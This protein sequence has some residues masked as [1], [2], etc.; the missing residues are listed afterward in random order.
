M[1]FERVNGYI[2]GLFS[3]NEL[4]RKAAYIQRTTLKTFTPVV[5]DDVARLLRLLVR[6]LRPRRILE[7]G[8]SIG[9]STFSLACAMADRDGMITT[10][11]YEPLVA[12]Q[13]REN[14]IRAGVADR[15]ETLVGDAREILPGL[16]P[17]YDLIFQD[18]D[19]KLYPDMLPDCLRLLRPGGLLLADD[20]LFPVMDLDVQWQDL[21]DPIDR[22]NRLV[23]SNPDLESTL[24]P[25]GDG[26]VMA[27]KK[28]HD[29]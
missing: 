11:E 1:E 17:G 20:A 14:F 13:A 7:I 9:Y 16:P 2:E 18:A 25:I 22:F 4:S 29:S 10:I 28:S 24:L 5:D 27:V 21:C 3:G 19:K 8:T 12:A 6:L 26:L 15:I 23:A